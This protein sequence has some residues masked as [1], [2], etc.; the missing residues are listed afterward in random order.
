MSVFQG[1]DRK[2]NLSENSDDRDVLNNLGVAPIADDISLFT[3]NLRNTSELIV[4]VDERQGNRIVFDPDAQGFIFT[5]GTPITVFAGGNTIVGNYYVGNSNNVN[6]FEI[7]SDPS[8]SQIVFPPAGVD[9]RYVR[10]DA[11]EKS[12]VLNLVKPRDPVVEVQSL[13]QLLNSSDALDSVTSNAYTSIRR[14]Y[15]LLGRTNAS[16]ITEYM[17]EIESEL[18]IFQQKKQKSIINQVDFSTDQ[19]IIVNGSV[20]VSDPAGINDESVSTTSGPGIFIL[21]AST[22]QAKRAFS[23]NENVWTAEPPLPATATD[24]VA[25]TREIVVGNLVFEDGVRITRKAGLPTIAAGTGSVNNF[26]HF[27]KVTVNGEDYSLCLI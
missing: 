4:T 20:I 27:V 21:D 3:N 25:A 9:V 19:A 24:L 13:S 15:S 12:D 2:L 22:N 17:R 26:T 7:F 10:S 6:E 14:I 11:I 16:T 23:D 1:F 8:L 5:N 18:D